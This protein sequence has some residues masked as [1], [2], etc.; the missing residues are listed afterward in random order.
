M[1]ENISSLKHTGK[2]CMWACEYVMW[3]CNLS[4]DKPLHP[5]PWGC[6]I[7]CL[8]ASSGSCLPSPSIPA[9]PPPVIV[10]GHS[11]ALW[12]PIAEKD[13]SVTHRLWKQ[14]ILF[15]WTAPPTAL[16]LSTNL[17]LSLLLFFKT[18]NLFAPPLSC[19][20]WI[21]LLMPNSCLQ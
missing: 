13:S 11:V 12:P 20:P 7:S 4:I 14:Y 16:M 21:A 8:L 1:L 5:H 17:C 18:P 6:W 3:V 15:M 2:T 10:A 9:S 19:P